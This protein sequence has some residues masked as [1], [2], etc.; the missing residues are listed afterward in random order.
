MQVMIDTLMAAFGID[1]N[2]FYSATEQALAKYEG[3][4]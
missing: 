4:K 3:A 2:K 1:P